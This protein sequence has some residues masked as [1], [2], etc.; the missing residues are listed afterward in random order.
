MSPAAEALL[1]IALVLVILILVS[2]LA[3]AAYAATIWLL[4]RRA[5]KHNEKMIAEAERQRLQVRQEAEKRYK[6]FEEQRQKK[7]A[8]MKAKGLE[9]VC[10]MLAG[11]YFIECE[12][13]NVIAMYDIDNKR[14]PLAYLGL[15]SQATTVGVDP[16]IYYHQ[17]KIPSSKL[18][19]DD[20]EVRKAKTQD[21]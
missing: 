1:L 19:Y 2:Y 16:V 20:I 6:E 17:Y 9:K 10:G 4:V 12:G 7:I 14:V 15:S 13:S 11:D 18:I 8:N 21:R 5:N 3:R